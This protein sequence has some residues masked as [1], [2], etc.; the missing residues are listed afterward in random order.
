MAKSAA[1]VR[2]FEAPDLQYKLVST[3]AYFAYVQH[4]FAQDARSV[5]KRLAENHELLTL[6]GVYFGE[7]QGGYLRFA[8]ANLAADRF[9]EA[10]RRLISSQ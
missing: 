8:F 3:G 9:P 4:P 1:I 6:P 5:A 2:A 7:G 10:V